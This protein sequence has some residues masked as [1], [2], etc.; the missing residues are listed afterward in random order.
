MAYATAKGIDPNLT[1]ALDAGKELF[2]YVNNYASGGF[3]V[4]WNLVMNG[5]TM[6]YVWSS[7]TGAGG[8]Y[9]SIDSLSTAN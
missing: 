2:T 5:H 8:L 3:G 1:F 6:E 4:P 7:T 9:D